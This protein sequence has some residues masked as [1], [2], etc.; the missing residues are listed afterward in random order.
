M[1]RAWGLFFR[2]WSVDAKAK[3]TSAASILA[4]AATLLGFGGFTLAESEYAG[5]FLVLLAIIVVL[6]LVT[7]KPPLPQSLKEI[8]KADRA[9]STLNQVTG[10]DFSFGVLGLKDAGKTTFIRNV[11]NLPNERKETAAPYYRLTP[12]QTTGGVKWATFLDGPG[13]HKGGAVR[14][15]SE[16][17]KIVLLIDH[18]GS[19][20]VEDFDAQRGKDHISYAESIA[21]L[22]EEFDFPVSHIILQPNKVDLWGAHKESKNSMDGLIDEVEKILKDRQIDPRIFSAVPMSAENG[23][24]TAELLSVLVE[25]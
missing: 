14:I 17:Q 11:L 24:S 12:I 13:G 2:T 5:A 23:S 9:I 18:N 16:A 19:S 7:A 25:D 20:S 1:N 10:N 21:E 15:L 8:A 22:I 6:I 4:V 3:L